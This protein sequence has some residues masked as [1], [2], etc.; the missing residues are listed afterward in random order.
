MQADQMALSPLTVSPGK[1]PGL[2]YP[3]LPQEL[4]IKYTYYC[5][6]SCCIA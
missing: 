4:Q 3:T 5:I 6:F 2:I 1:A